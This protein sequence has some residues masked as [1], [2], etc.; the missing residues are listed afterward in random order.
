[1]LEIIELTLWSQSRLIKVCLEQNPCCDVVPMQRGG[2]EGCK[3]ETVLKNPE[4][5]SFRHTSQS[6][7]NARTYRWI[8][9]PRRS[10]ER[11]TM[12]GWSRVYKNSH[13][14]ET[15][16]RIFLLKPPFFSAC[17]QGGDRGD[18]INPAVHVNNKHTSL[19]RRF[20]YSHSLSCCRCM[21]AFSLYSLQHQWDSYRVILYRNRSP[22]RSSPS[23]GTALSLKLA[24]G[25][26]CTHEQVCCVSFRAG[27]WVH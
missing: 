27:E 23:R 22:L 8:S 18:R 11:P 10:R 5:E 13:F 16:P 7:I 15:N 6:N 25:S 26:F 17:L 2:S 1:M 20:L 21:W 14:R 19:I 9:S 3:A 4:T 12:E 24:R